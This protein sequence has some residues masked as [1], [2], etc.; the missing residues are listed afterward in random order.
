MAK[1]SKRITVVAVPGDTPC[2]ELKR[3]LEGRQR[4][5]VAE[6]Q[7]KIRGVELMARRSRMR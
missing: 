6:V 4:E 1:A 3:M 2:D 5:L 7:G